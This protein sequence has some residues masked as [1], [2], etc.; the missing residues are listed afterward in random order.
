MIRALF[1]DIDGTVVSF[2]THQIPATALNA[3]QTAHANGVRIVIATGRVPAL[4]CPLQGIPVD[5]WITAN[6]AAIYDAHFHPIIEKFLPQES[7]ARLA[8]NPPPDVGWFFAD[9][10][11]VAVPSIHAKFPLL[12]DLLNLDLPHNTTPWPQIAKRQWIQ[13]GYFLTPEDDHG[14]IAEWLPGCKALRWHPLFADITRADTEKANGVEVLSRHFDIPLSEC[15][16]FGDGENDISM[17]RL[18]GA[19]VA[20]GNA[21]LSVKAASDFVTDS[22]D[23]DGLANALHHLGVLP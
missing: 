21:N 1:L 16:A 10:A 3:L 9:R 23:D 18:A 14:Q 11:G 17:I 15:A 4:L 2:K 20:M 13:A 7:I 19:G 6:G 22:V 12:R 8:S 5:A